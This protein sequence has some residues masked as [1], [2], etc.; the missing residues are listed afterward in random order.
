MRQAKPQP[1]AATSPTL[2]DLVTEYVADI[3]PGA[4]EEI[5]T[6][7]GAELNGGEWGVLVWS[8]A[9][10]LGDAC[11]EPIE[12]AAGAIITEML[13]TGTIPAEAIAPLALHVAV[14]ARTAGAEFD[15]QRLATNY[16]V[17]L[18]AAIE[19]EAPGFADYAVEMVQ[20]TARRYAR[21]YCHAPQ[22]PIPSRPCLPRRRRIHRAQSRR[23]PPSDDSDPSDPSAHGRR[24][25]RSA[26]KGR[27][28]RSVSLAGHLTAAIRAI[29][30]THLAIKDAA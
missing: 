29:R 16:I 20:A 18:I 6:E 10:I 24:A 19:A 1:D 28:R 4:V 7:M 5:A 22:Y 25:A 11:D 21:R 9:Q 30:R 15:T 14:V 27:A 13:R 3:L 23:G 26:N 8:T 12:D 2:D 17:P